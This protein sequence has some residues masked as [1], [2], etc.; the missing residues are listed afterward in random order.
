MLERDNYCCKI[1]GSSSHP[2]VH[3]KI[4][5]ARGGKGCLENCVVWCR[6]CH[7]NYHNKWG[8]TTSDDY[9]NPVGEYISAN[10]VHKKRTKRKR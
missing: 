10:K 9:G 2:T 5:K 1:C 4:A 7:R 3:H 6:E 8:I